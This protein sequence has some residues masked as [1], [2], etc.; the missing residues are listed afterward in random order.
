MAWIGRPRMYNS[1]TEKMKAYREAKKQRG[2]VRLDCYLP[3]VYRER[4]VDVCREA[5]SSF[6]D[7]ICFLLD[8][9]SAHRNN[10]P[11]SNDESCASEA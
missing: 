9:Y 5:R 1:A 11:R 8:F 4:L 10:A 3:S 2:A 6:G 7:G